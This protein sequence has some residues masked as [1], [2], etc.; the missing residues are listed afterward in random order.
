MELNLAKEVA[1]LERMTTKQLQEKFAE[2][3]GE[4]TRANN[5]TWLFRRIAWRLR[6]AELPCD[7]IE[8][9]SSTGEHLAPAYHRRGD[10]VI[11]GDTDRGRGR[12]DRLEDPTRFLARGP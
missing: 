5:R 12:N 4:P 2:V 9:G 1:A 6:A 11:T 3:F 7:R 10:A 8:D